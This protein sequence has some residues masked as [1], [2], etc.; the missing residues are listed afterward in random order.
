MT[1]K[2]NNILNT[3]NVDYLDKTDNTKYLYGGFVQDKLSFLDGKLDLIFGIKAESWQLVSN[4]WYV[5]PSARFAIK[6]NDKHTIWGAASRSVTT[7]GFIH[8]NI[9]FSKY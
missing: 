4:S 2:V 6:P 5:S 1:F 3:D 8:T 7:P 9:L